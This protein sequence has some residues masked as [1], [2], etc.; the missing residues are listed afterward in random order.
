MSA[1]S[2][3]YHF[4]LEMGAS[5]DAGG[6]GGTGCFPYYYLILTSHV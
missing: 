4:M 1:F 3:L 6:G 2:L 5:G